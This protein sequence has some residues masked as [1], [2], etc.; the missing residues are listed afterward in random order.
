MPDF[1]DQDESL[2]QSWFADYEEPP[3]DG[4]VAQATTWLTTVL[5]R[6][7]RSQRLGVGAEP[8]KK[9]VPKEVEVVSQF[10][11]RLLRRKARRDEEEDEERRRVAERFGGGVRRRVVQ[12][13]EAN[14][15][16]SLVV[17]ASGQRKGKRPRRQ[18]WNPIADATGPSQGAQESTGAAEE[19]D[20]DDAELRSARGGGSAST[21]HIAFKRH[22]SGARVAGVGSIKSRGDTTGK[23]ST[24]A[25]GVSS[26]A[27]GDA[28][29][30]LLV[31]AT[32]RQAA[33]AAKR[34]RR[35]ENKRQKATDAGLQS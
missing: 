14:S 31:A 11:R 20:D 10:A 26:S 7:P 35:K 30:E 3:K 13:S 15:R 17:G 4:E 24:P 27:R 25:V 5:A 34:R 16:E 9:D 19:S 12:T 33:D 21:A 28:L 18:S 29:A 23:L 8:P 32:S 6:P 2:V 22:A 1:V